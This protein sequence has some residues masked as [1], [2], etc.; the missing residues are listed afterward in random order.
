MSLTGWLLEITCCQLLQQ[1][2][3][4]PGWQSP[5]WGVWLR[6]CWGCEELQSPRGPAFL[7]PL[8]SRAGIAS[9]VPGE[10]TMQDG[11]R[12]DAWPQLAFLLRAVS[13]GWMSAQVELYL[14]IFPHHINAQL[15]LSLLSTSSCT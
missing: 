5:Q 11:Q 3:Q 4:Y 7:C 1:A 9:L 15:K 13:E 6:A 8:S 12:H 2:Q 14:G 10:Q